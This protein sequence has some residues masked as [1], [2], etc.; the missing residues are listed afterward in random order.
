VYSPCF[1]G[2]RIAPGI[3]QLLGL[4]SV[5]LCHIP[6]THESSLPHRVLCKRYVRIYEDSTYGVLAPLCRAPYCTWNS[7]APWTASTP[8]LPYSSHTRVLLSRASC[9]AV[10]FSTRNV[11]WDTLRRLLDSSG[12]S[13]GVSVVAFPIIVRPKWQFQM[14]VGLGGATHLNPCYRRRWTS[15]SIRTA[16]VATTSLGASRWTTGTA[17]TGSTYHA[18]SAQPRSA[19]EVAR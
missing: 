1:A 17:P 4:P 12:V 11:L 9:S 3:W 19:S 14:S 15:A 2:L 5:P 13:H 7:A 16:S 6:I 8:T 10:R 18:P